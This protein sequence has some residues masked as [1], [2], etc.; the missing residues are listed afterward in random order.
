MAP[1]NPDQI[2]VFGVPLL[3]SNDGGITYDRIDSLGN[4][5]SDHQALW[6]N[7]KNAQHLRLGNDG[8]LYESHDG[9]AYWRHIN[10]MPVGQFYTVNV[11]FESPYNIYGGLQDNGS[12]V[13]SSQSVPNRTIHWQRIFGG[14]GMFVAP[15]PRDASLVYT[16][17]QFGNYYRKDL[18]KNDVVRITPMHDI[19][20]PKLRF[21]WRTPMKLSEHNP[22]IVYMGAQKM[23]RSFDQGNSWKPI[24]PDLTKNLPQGKCTLLYH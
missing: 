13:G 9:G 4:V 11:D 19:G 16:G 22:D 12:L 15:D 17:F 5:H 14:D 10:N 24:S 23:F 2:Y 18:K 6:I 3:K 21:N 7:P 1:D 8:G 20:E